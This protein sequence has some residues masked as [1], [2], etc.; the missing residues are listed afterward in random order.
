MR[1][2]SVAGI[3]LAVAL[4][5][6][7]A[8]PSPC[9]AEDYVAKKGL[10]LY[11]SDLQNL[12]QQ[13]L[14]LGSSA[15]DQRT[16]LHRLFEMKFAEAERIFGLCGQE[17]EVRR[18]VAELY[19]MRAI[20]NRA[21]GNWIQTYFSLKDAETWNPDALRQVVDM[22][23]R[24]FEMTAFAKDLEGE[25]RAKGNNVRFRIKSFDGGQMFRVDNVILAE[26]YEQG[27]G[28]GPGDGAAT[29]FSSIGQNG[30]KDGITEQ[31]WAF[32]RD[33]FYKSLYAYYYDPSEQNAEFELYLPRGDYYVYEK[34]FALHPVE[35][36]VST[37]STQVIL[38]PAR[39]FQ[40]TLSE[41]VHPS[42]VR[43]SFHGM[44][45]TDLTHVPFGTYKIHIKNKRYTYPSVK[46][47]F[48]PKG[49]PSYLNEM[50]S[51]VAEE[52]VYVDD[53]GVYQLAFQ[54]RNSSEKLRY[55]LLGY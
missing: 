31:D 25:M 47:T 21:V 22:G 1:C 19:L 44:E 48:V 34:D 4:A 29:G 35:F 42:N 9:G 6:A 38:Q 49:D 3:V 26:S 13:I 12:A 2:R 43:L 8:G 36:T 17:D 40:M 39:W 45:W 14:A 37:Q 46:V 50:G 24:R 11:R 54:E 20:E 15:G 52:A 5:V 51:Q 55:K 41:E 23:G 53:R 18:Q 33:R 28:E 16:F 32:L 10:T 30:R 7:A 27:E